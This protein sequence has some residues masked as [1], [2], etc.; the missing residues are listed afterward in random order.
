MEEPVVREVTHPLPP[1]EEEQQLQQDAPVIEPEEPQVQKRY[2][3]EGLDILKKQLRGKVILSIDPN[4]DDILKETF[5]F[6][7]IKQNLPMMI[8]QPLTNVDV[9]NTLKFAH[10]YNI[11]Y[12]VR[13]GGFSATGNCFMKDGIMIDLSLMKGIQ[14]D[15]K[16]KE[17]IVEPGCNVEDLEYETN[18]F[19]FTVPS[20]N[21][22]KVGISGLALHGGYSFLSRKFGLMSDNLI[23]VDVVLPNEKLVQV[24][25]KSK[26][27]KDLMY[28]IRGSGGSFGII[29]KLKFKMHKIPESMFGGI[30]V[31]NGVTI[32]ELFASWRKLT[33][34]HMNDRDFSSSF[35]I[36]PLPK[37]EV[38]IAVFHLTSHKIGEDIVSELKKVGGEPISSSFGTKTIT[39]IQDEM[40]EFFEIAP[41]NKWTSRSILHTEMTNEFFDTLLNGGVYDIPRECDQTIFSIELWGGQ[42]NSKSS[43]STPIP[44]RGSDYVVSMRAGWGDEEKDKEHTYWLDGL[45]AKLTEFCQHHRTDFPCYETNPCLRDEKLYKLKEK[46][47]PHSEIVGGIHILTK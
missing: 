27:A 13:A 7:M 9:I 18:H 23:S 16:N 26:E 4:F 43:S 40:N 45:K 37:L 17:V 21:F 24:D 41:R 44:V 35:Y 20:G 10:Q 31:Y 12:S 25:E 6:D 29:T 14:V 42:I 1:V 11:H 32:K 36:K 22:K 3:V 38:S 30:L 15:L 28:G 46:Y 39:E 34:Y 8:I 2:S 19:G 33:K 5:N 47:D